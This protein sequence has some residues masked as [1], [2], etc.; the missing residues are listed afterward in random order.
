M[1]LDPPARAVE[2]GL[3]FEMEVAPLPPAALQP[4]LSNQGIPVRLVS[5]NF[6]LL[7]TR[8]LRV[9]T[10]RGAG[11]IPFKRFGADGVLDTAPLPFTGDVTVRALGWRRGGTD[12]LWRVAQDAP[13][14]CTILSVSTLIKAGDA[15]GA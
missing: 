3:P 5:A 6:R 12:P 13:L 8:A 9:D 15:S 11:D 14:P 10:G 4:R 1:T 2:I 7:A